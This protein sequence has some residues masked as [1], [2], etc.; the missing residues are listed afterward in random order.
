MIY[1][2]LVIVITFFAASLGYALVE[3]PVYDVELKVLDKNLDTRST[4]YVEGFSQVVNNLTGLE[5]DLTGHKLPE[6]LDKYIN[7]YSYKDKDGDLLLQLKY[8]DVMF[9]DW[10]RSQDIPYLGKN[11]PTL[12]LLLKVS[13]G[14]DSNYVSTDKFPELVTTIETL[15]KDINIPVVLPLMDLEEIS[16]LRA[17]HEEATLDSTLKTFARKYSADKVLVGSIVAANDMENPSA[18]SWDLKYGSD[19]RFTTTE[20]TMEEHIAVMYSL[21]FQKLIQEYSNKG[22]SQMVDGILV[23]IYGVDSIDK[24]S[25]ILAYLK[26]LDGVTQVSLTG[27]ASDKTSFVLKANSN[28][29]LVQQAIGVDSILQATTEADAITNNT[30]EYRI[31]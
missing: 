8:N 25:K 13:N 1:R 2:L 5:F 22:A 28:A 15:A 29:N 18:A 4:A 23:N 12:L 26:S 24:Y 6:S 17:L 7:N 21:L 16:M 20:D 11:R 10:L 14:N 9:N 19:Y 27:V 3:K 31:D 30:L